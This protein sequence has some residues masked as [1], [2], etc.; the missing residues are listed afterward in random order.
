MPG[1]L[2]CSLARSLSLPFSLSLF[3][4][5]SVSLSVTLSPASLRA[6]L[7][8]GAITFLPCKLG[9]TS[10]H[11]A[12]VNVL[13]QLHSRVWQLRRANRPGRRSWVHAASLT[14]LEPWCLRRLKLLDMA[15]ERQ[16]DCLPR[17][18]LYALALQSLVSEWAQSNLLTKSAWVRMLRYTH[19]LGGAV[20]PNAGGGNVWFPH[21]AILLLLAH[22]SVSTR[23]AN[24]RYRSY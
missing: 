13:Q 6:C 19:T 23:L 2:A 14:M 5:L 21:A 3:L 20:H 7:Q 11:K 10:G 9:P 17:F 18:E 4:C 24:F 12:V 15:I 22:G 16:C 8:H 1:L